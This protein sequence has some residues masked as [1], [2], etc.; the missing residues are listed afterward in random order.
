[1]SRRIKVF[2][3]CGLIAL[4]ATVAISLICADD[5]Y[6][7]TNWA[8]A[9]MLWSEVFLFGGLTVIECLAKRSE[10]IVTRTL[11]YPIISIYA[12][13]EFLISVLYMTLLNEATVSFEV[14]QVILLAVTLTAI[15]ISIGAGKGA[16]SSSVRAARAVENTESMIERLNK[17]ACRPE[18]E[19]FAK[20]LKGLSDDLRF[21]DI[22][23]TVAEDAKI[24]DIISA[25]EVRIACADG[26]DRE[27]IEADI[28]HLNTL[29]LQRKASVS[30]AS[31]G[32]I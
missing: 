20:A 1:M 21:T 6:G 3:T 24:I 25:I 19:P 11:L 7:L 30:A 22:S 12:A 8:F 17:L 14:L 26:F 15:A 10:Q 16:Q 28:A 23:K 31:K 4:L 9:T 18:C 29:I 32:K 13:V 5:W 27:Q 2:L